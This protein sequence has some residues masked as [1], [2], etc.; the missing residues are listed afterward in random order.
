MRKRSDNCVDRCNDAAKRNDG[1]ILR[2]NNCRC[3]SEHFA[4]A[5]GIG[6]HGTRST[7]CRCRRIECELVSVFRR[8]FVIF[9]PY[10]GIDCVEWYPDRWERKSRNWRKGRI[11]GLH[12]PLAPNGCRF[13][14]KFGVNIVWKRR[15]RTIA[16]SKPP[17]GKSIDDVVHS[18][19]PLL[20]LILLAFCL[21]TKQQTRCE[22][23]FF[24]VTPKRKN[25]KYSLFRVESVHP[26]LVARGLLGFICFCAAEFHKQWLHVGNDTDTFSVGSFRLQVFG[27]GI[28]LRASYTLSSRA[29][30]ASC[31]ITTHLTPC[32]TKIQTR[33]CRKSPPKHFQDENT[34][35]SASIFR[36]SSPVPWMLLQSSSVLWIVFCTI[37]DPSW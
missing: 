8:D 17:A 1:R 23:F 31:N 13:A 9:W 7:P 24:V 4:V 6:M 11:L 25:E 16:P 37:P 15:R 2:C 14:R 36:N 33:K 26:S 18:T 21:D 19:R 35:M 32:H 34:K 10:L 3:H 5:D 27:F 29:N 28:L 20:F 22:F 12:A 30:S